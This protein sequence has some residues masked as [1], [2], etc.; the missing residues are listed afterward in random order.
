MKEP[1]FILLNVGELLFKKSFFTKDEFALET[2]FWKYGLHAK[3]AFP[4]L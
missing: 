1:E 2:N 3:S 4:E